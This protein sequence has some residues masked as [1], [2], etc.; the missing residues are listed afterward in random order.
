MSPEFK[1]NATN[2]M[3][4]I[5]K[6]VHEL[7]RPPASPA[8]SRQ[9]RTWAELSLCLAVLYKFHLLSEIKY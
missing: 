9:P 1:A 8:S 3:A 4:A 6:T 5:K 2:T 7:V